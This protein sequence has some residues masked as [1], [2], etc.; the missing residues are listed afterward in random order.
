MFISFKDNFCENYTL[1]FLLLHQ[2][3]RG[4]FIPLRGP[5][6]RKGELY[7]FKRA[8]EKKGGEERGRGKGERYSRGVRERGGERG[9]AGRGGENKS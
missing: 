5:R 4:N 9:V 2:V 7:P 6:I 8:T 1:H 3:W